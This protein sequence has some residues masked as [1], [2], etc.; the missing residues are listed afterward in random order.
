[1]VLRGLLSGDLHPFPLLV[2]LRMQLPVV[3]VQNGFV[4]LQGADLFP[5]SVV[6]DHVAIEM[7]GDL[8]RGM[9]TVRVAVGLGGSGLC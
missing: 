1:M 2:Q 6:P 9:Q 4:R 7:D 5:E 8:G 3:V